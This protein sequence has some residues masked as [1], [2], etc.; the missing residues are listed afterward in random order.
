MFEELHKLIKKLK[1]LHIQRT[2]VVTELASVDHK[3]A[4]TLDVATKGK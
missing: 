3:I 4:V 2:E 1:I